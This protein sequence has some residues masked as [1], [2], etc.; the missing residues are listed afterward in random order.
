ME[1]AAFDTDDLA[2][3]SGKAP[4]TWIGKELLATVRRFNPALVTNADG[5]YKESTG[6]VGGWEKSELRS[7]LKN[8]VKPLIPLVVIEA[9]VETKRKQGAYDTSG[10]YFA[11]TTSDDVWIPSRGEI[12]GM[13]CT[14]E[15]FLNASGTLEKLINGV[16]EFWSLRDTS[17][18][19]TSY[20]L[21]KNGQPYNASKVE[22]ESGICLCFCT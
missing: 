11:Q 12:W 9:I 1:I 3:D 10:N 21:N 22:V 7:Y 4:I 19:T 5:T 15:K 20:I 18:T 14:Y 13:L 8:T 17:S 6:G 16:G 2:D